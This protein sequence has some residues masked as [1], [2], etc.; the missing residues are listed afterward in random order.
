MAFKDSIKE[1]FRD[2][3]KINRERFRKF[4]LNAPF[5]VLLA[6]VVLIVIGLVGAGKLKAAREDQNMAK[7]WQQGASTTYRQMSV[8]ARGARNGDS[9]A[10][11]TYV[12]TDI[13]LKKSDVSLI[14]TALQ[15]VV[16]STNGQNKTVAA[17]T[18]PIGWEDAYSTTVDATVSLPTANSSDT[19]VTADAQLVGVGG[20][21]RAFHPFKY[22]SGGFL[23]ETICDTNQIVLNDVLAWRFYKS[24][25]VTGNVVLIGGTEY[26]IIGVVRE[27][28]S[29]VDEL[30][31]TQVPR[32]YIYFDTLA[33]TYT[34]KSDSSS[35]SSAASGTSTGSSAGTS[36]GS[37][38]S[39]SASAGST[40]ASG[41]STGSTGSD[42]DSGNAELAIQCYEAMLPE[43]V[44]GVANSDVKN[45]LPN[46]SINN[47]QLYVVSDTGRF[48]LTRVWDWM[49]PIGQS[50]SEL[51]NYDFPFWEKAA[52]ITTTRL[53]YEYAVCTSGIVLLFIGGTMAI[54]RA[55][56]LRRPGKLLAEPETPLIPENTGE[57]PES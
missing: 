4:V 13:S 9:T 28:D 17:V 47:P 1:Y 41:T 30:A 12:D 7:Y 34:P 56:K 51:A 42:S 52:Q 27:G 49:F 50:E 8:Y 24:Y 18:A 55:R 54:L 40:A 10:P 57:E 3:G 53:F 31:G 11:L 14:R 19:A 15:G 44:V 36:T 37:T 43:L 38:S 6:A 22:M 16:N 32:A 25:E 29:S 2:T 35:N 5:F 48:S 21:F 45:A 33:K 20:N 46:Y 26:T 23:P 39:T